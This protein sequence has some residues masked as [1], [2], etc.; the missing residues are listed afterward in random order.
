[1][2]YS[3][4]YVFVEGNDDERFFDRIIR[5][6]LKAT[7]CKVIKY[8]EAPRRQIR[9]FLRSIIQMEA[10]YIYFTDIN[11]APCVTEKK[12]KVRQ[13]IK[14]GID[15]SKVVIVIKEIESWYLA[16]VDENRA[17]ELKI[18]VPNTTDSISKEQ[19]ASMVSSR[20]ERKDLMLEILKDF[21]V[22]TAKRKNKSFSYFV[23]KYC[24]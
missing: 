13:A 21:S 8:A 24:P 2:G 1:M 9:D 5:P 15:E 22:D 18:S 6:R 11:N 7:Y 23:Q 3:R 10:D 4:L 12:H 14:S 19:F 17:K 16:G 20:W